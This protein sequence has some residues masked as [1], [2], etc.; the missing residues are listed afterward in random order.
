MIS[1]TLH[2]TYHT[3]ASALVKSALE[4]ANLIITSEDLTF[5]PTS[6]LC[7]PVYKNPVSISEQQVSTTEVSMDEGETLQT[8]LNNPV[9][10]QEQSLSQQ[11]HLSAEE[12]IVGM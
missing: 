12:V 10:E 9:S 5:S 1:D 8:P 6:F 11:A 2:V 7:S 3:S 4:D